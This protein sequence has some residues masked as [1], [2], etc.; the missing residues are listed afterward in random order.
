MIEK[1]I[2]QGQEAMRKDIDIIKT[3]VEAEAEV[4]VETKVEIEDIGIKAEVGAE[5]KV[6][7][8]SMKEGIKAIRKITNIEEAEKREENIMMKLIVVILKV[9][10]Q[11]KIQKKKLKMN[12]EKAYMKIVILRVKL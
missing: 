8:G 11:E 2:V 1:D 6:E 7:I 9:M 10:I 3:G 5:Q 4:E 12:I